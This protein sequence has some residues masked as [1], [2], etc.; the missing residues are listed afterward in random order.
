MC[1]KA[2]CLRCA[3]H[4]QHTQCSRR[5]RRPAGSQIQGGALPHLLPVRPAGTTEM[6]NAYC[7]AD[8]VILRRVYSQGAG[9]TAHPGPAGPQLLGGAAGQ[10]WVPGPPAPP[11]TPPALAPAG[12]VHAFIMHDM[13]KE[14]MNLFLGVV[15][16]ARLP[17]ACTLPTSIVPSA[18]TGMHRRQPHRHSHKHAIQEPKSPPTR[19]QPPPLVLLLNQQVGSGNG[20]RHDARTDSEAGSTAVG[21]AGGCSRGLHGNQAEGGGRI[22]RGAQGVWLGGWPARRADK[23]Q[24]G[25]LFGARPLR[26]WLCGCVG[27][28][29][30]GAMPSARSCMLDRNSTV[31][32]SQGTQHEHVGHAGHSHRLCLPPKWW[33]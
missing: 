29:G 6:A 18:S 7:S 15:E 1:I 4:T 32:V 30:G 28:G 27:R 10:Q 14:L 21:S 20:C 26:V 3:A 13:A 5:W 33:T 16:W 25:V 2:L 12:T 19:L 31:C 22:G 11:H 24:R 23:M 9:R 8:Q 17:V